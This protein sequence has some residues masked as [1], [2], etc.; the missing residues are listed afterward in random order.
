MERETSNAFESHSRLMTMSPL[1]PCGKPCAIIKSES[2]GK[3]ETHRHKSNHTG[4][5]FNKIYLF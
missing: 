2:T 3:Q 1:Y 5:A 4:I